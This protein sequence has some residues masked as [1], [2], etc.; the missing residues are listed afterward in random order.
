MNRLLGALLTLATIFGIRVYNKHSAAQEVRAKLETLCAGD[1]TCLASVASNFDACFE[2]AYSI[3]SRRRDSQKVA[4][5]LVGCLN[6]KSG[7]EYFVA[8]R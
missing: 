1:S 8:K 5:A 7:E 3:A 6:Q 2:D 4:Q